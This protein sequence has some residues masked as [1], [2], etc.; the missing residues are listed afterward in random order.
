M[1][2]KKTVTKRVV[3]RS[4]STPKKKLHR[5][6]IEAPKLLD[7]DFIPGFKTLRTALLC[8]VEDPA[9]WRETGLP[10]ERMLRDAGLAVLIGNS[11]GV[12]AF[13]EAPKKVLVPSLLYA[14][15]VDYVLCACHT[16]FRKAA[17][18]AAK[19]LQHDQEVSRAAQ[20]KNKALMDAAREAQKGRDFIP[21]WATWSGAGL[22]AKLS[23]GEV[24][25]DSRVYEYTCTCGKGP[26]SVDVQTVLKG[27]QNRGKHPRRKLCGP[28]NWRRSGKPATQVAVVR[29]ALPGAANN[30]PGLTVPMAEVVQ[31]NKSPSA[32]IR[33]NKQQKKK[34]PAPTPGS[35][36]PMSAL[37]AAAPEAPAT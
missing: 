20:A 21:D 32:K 6:V 24:L 23:S 16:P 25:P 2:A 7:P 22:E 3:K 31:F 13:C 17:R 30:A 9:G 34:G 12:C 10:G 26:I 37:P 18:E 1:T 27:L 4:A 14:F 33:K 28:C 36:Q 5:P 19:K 15:H 8:A 11:R 29:Q 35:L